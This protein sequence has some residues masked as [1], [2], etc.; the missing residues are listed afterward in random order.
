MGVGYYPSRPDPGWAESEVWRMQRAAR[1][2]VWIVMSDY[3]HG[4]LDERAVLMQAVEA[5]GGEVVFTHAA[6]DAVLYRVRFHPAST[7]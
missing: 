7:E 3:A 5:G 4:T 6:A 2:Y 1:P